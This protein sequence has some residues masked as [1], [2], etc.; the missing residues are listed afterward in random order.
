MSAQ[1]ECKN[2]CKFAKIGRI[3]AEMSA[4][5]AE[6]CQKCSTILN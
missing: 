2:E 5:L 6:I 3:F 4:F 1:K